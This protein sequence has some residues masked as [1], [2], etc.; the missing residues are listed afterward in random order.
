[1]IFI[2][3]YL[4]IG[5]G[6]GLVLHWLVWSG[7]FYEYTEHKEDVLKLRN[8]PFIKVA[9]VYTYLIFTWIVPV[10]QYLLYKITKKKGDEK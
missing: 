7:E 3:I 2:L 5:T 9:L 6:W 10:G 1:M 8:G 4:I